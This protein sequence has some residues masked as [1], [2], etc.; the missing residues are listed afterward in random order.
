M[1]FRADRLHYIANHIEK[2]EH[3]MRKQT[4]MTSLCDDVI[5]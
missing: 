4:L 5:R 1:I 2:R 3:V